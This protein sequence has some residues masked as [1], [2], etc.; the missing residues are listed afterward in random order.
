MFDKCSDYAKRELNFMD[1][2]KLTVLYIINL[3]DKKYIT[4][5]ILRPLSEKKGI[6]PSKKLMTSALAS[7]PLSICTDAA[8]AR[9][10]ILSGNAVIAGEENGEFFCF[11]ADAKS[12]DGRSISEPLSESVVRGPRQ[13]FVENAM[14]NVTML[15]KIIKSEN[16]KVLSYTFGSNTRTD[17][18]VVYYEGIVDK[19]ALRILKERLEG[20]SMDSCVDSGN[21]E[22]MLQS[23]KFN[24]FSEVGN[25]EKPDKV[26]SKILGGRIAIICDGSPVVLTVPYLFTESIQSSEDYLKSVYYAAFI[27]LLRLIGM[28][29]AVILPAPFLAVQRFHKGALPYSIYKIQTQSRSDVPFGIFAEMLIVLVI[30]EIVREVGVRM[31]K[32]VG[33]ALSVVGGL[34]LG[35]AAIKAG[36]TSETVVVIAALTGICNFMNPTF[37]NANVIL[38]FAFVLLAGIFG[39]YGIA[40]GVISVLV[41]LCGKNSFGA[42]YM[43]PFTPASGRI[44]YDTVIMKPYAASYGHSREIDEDYE[45]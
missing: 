17:V 27:R 1:G 26:A 22:L 4:N 39:F 16:L 8:S 40:L 45:N 18:K 3:C 19:R 2:R 38:R 10:K 24:L 21:L 9:D 29:L 7:L 23:S 42:E 15:R 5:G 44:L 12:E 14:L 13:G 32:A 28:I 11:A 25:S 31:P 35:D 37:M 33:D 36:I 6:I 43:M 34:I 30:F 20:I 41:I